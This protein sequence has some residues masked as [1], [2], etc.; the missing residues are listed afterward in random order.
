MRVGEDQCDS[1]VNGAG[2]LPL[3]MGGLGLCSAVR[4]SNSAFWAS[5]ADS[6]PMVRERPLVTGMIV[7]ALDSATT[8]ILSTIVEAT[9]VVQVG[10]FGPPNWATLSHGARP[11]PCE[12]DDF[13]PPRKNYRPELQGHLRQKQDFLDP[14]IW[15][16]MQSN[17]W[18]DIANLQR[19]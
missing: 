2:S 11:P 18:K 8:P 13:E 12:P 17:T 10:N 15:K 6:L 7:D 5:W 9:R 16:V 14:M 4:T 19:K 1:L 3:N